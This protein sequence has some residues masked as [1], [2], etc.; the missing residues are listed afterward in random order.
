MPEG[1][2][3]TFAELDGKIKNKIS[4]RAQAYRKLNEYLRGSDVTPV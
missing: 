4:H 2:V 3:E 1:Y